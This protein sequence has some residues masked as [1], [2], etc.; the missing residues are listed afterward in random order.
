[1][2]RHRAPKQRVSST[3]W[4]VAGLLNYHQLKSSQF[5]LL[6]P[7][8]L[9]KIKNFHVPPD[10][11][12]TETRDTRG[13]SVWVHSSEFGFLDSNVPHNGLPERLGQLGRAWWAT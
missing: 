7:T 8:K 2:G 10:T 12:D 5:S 4:E 11:I 13:R 3:S 6:R 9:D 1:M